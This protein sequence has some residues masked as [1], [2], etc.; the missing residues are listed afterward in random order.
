[1][2]LSIGHAPWKNDTF[3]RNPQ[4]TQACIIDELGENH[5]GLVTHPR[6]KSVLLE[7][8]P[9]FLIMASLWNKVNFPWGKGFSYGTCLQ[10][11]RPVLSS[12]FCFRHRGWSWTRHVE[13]VSYACW[14]GLPFLKA[15]IWVQCQNPRKAIQRADWHGHTLPSIRPTDSP[16]VE[17]SVWWSDQGRGL[18]GPFLFWQERKEAGLLL[19]SCSKGSLPAEGDFSLTLAM[20]SG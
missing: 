4:Q 8:L 11:R 7:G 3:P 15:P 12:W 6:F 10:L 9:V 17:P 14:A 2:A 16:V 19:L 1:M 13:K 20:I 18:T 5:L